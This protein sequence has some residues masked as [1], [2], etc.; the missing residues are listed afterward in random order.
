MPSYSLRWAASLLR[1]DVYDIATKVKVK[2]KNHLSSAKGASTSGP[3]LSEQA[4]HII[5]QPVETRNIETVTATA[6]SAQVPSTLYKALEGRLRALY[7]A[8]DLDVSHQERF[9]FRGSWLVLWTALQA[10]PSNEAFDIFRFVKLDESARV[11]A[12][13]HRHDSAAQTSS[14]PYE[15]SKMPAVPYQG[16]HDRVRNDSAISNVFVAAPG[17][18]EPTT[19][20]L[21]Y[22]VLEGASD[23]SKTALIAQRL[24]LCVWPDKDAVEILDT[25]GHPGKKFEQ[26]DELRL[27]F[28]NL[29]FPGYNTLTALPQ[30]LL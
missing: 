6:D 20:Q 28:R 10:C 23:V 2:V 24:L 29:L 18:S 3:L 25:I 27:R 26:K 15:V 5:E 13:L 16:A 7:V 14:P 11:A 22:G 8:R 1:R 9:R 17:P 30:L 12:L 4:V 21:W 19:S